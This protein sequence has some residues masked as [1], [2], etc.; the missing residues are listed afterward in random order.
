MR[1]NLIVPFAEKDTAKALGARWNAEKK[2]SY[3]K[4][5]ADLTSFLRWISIRCLTANHLI[6]GTGLKRQTVSQRC[7]TDYLVAESLSLI[8]Q[9]THD[10]YRTTQATALSA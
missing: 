8:Q 7:D 1:T 10:S 6:C 3:I 9:S 2:I 5:V 4:D